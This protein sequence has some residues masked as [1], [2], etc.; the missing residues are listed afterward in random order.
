MAVT[1]GLGFESGGYIRVRVKITTTLGIGFEDGGYFRVTEFCI[2]RCLGADYSSAT[3]L[4]Q[5]CLMT[6]LLPESARKQLMTISLVYYQ[7]AS[8]FIF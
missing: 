5:G 1:L 6:I 3:V 4:V 7:L 2:Y 8:N